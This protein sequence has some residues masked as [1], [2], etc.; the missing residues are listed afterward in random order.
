MCG[1]WQLGKIGKVC[2]LWQLGKMGK[3]WQ[4]CGCRWL[5]MAV[6]IRRGVT[7]NRSPGEPAM[8]LIIRRDV[9]L[10]R[11]HGCYYQT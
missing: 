7:D 2:G 9:A 11:S 3:I 10:A 4:L 1:L 5:A 6:I 8:A